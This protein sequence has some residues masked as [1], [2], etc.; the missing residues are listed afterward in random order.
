M[1]TYKNAEGLAVPSH[2]PSFWVSCLC[3]FLCYFL[4]SFITCAIVPPLKI[5]SF[6]IF[7]AFSPSVLE[8][9]LP[10]VWVEPLIQFPICWPLVQKI[11]PSRR[12]SWAWW[13]EDTQLH[14][15]RT[16]RHTSKKVQQEQSPCLH[17]SN[18]HHLS[19]GLLPP[20]VSLVWSTC[21]SDDTFRRQSRPW[22]SE[23]FLSP[24]WPHW[25]CVY[26]REK[27]QVNPVQGAS[28][29]ALFFWNL[30]NRPV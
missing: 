23:V 3:C 15:G 12:L 17:V 25:G 16:A 7:S 8:F 26:C 18:T 13:E 28:I 21:Q 14:K 6:S 24:C 19:L 1:Q 9:F 2:T 30:K 10:F 27:S 20:P 5:C 29:S 22:G 11:C 4:I